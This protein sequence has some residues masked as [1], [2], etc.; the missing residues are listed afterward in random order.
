MFHLGDLAPT[1]PHF[2]YLHAH[3][4]LTTAGSWLKAC[5][6]FYSAITA[7]KIESWLWDGVNHS[8]LAHTLMLLE[9]VLRRIWIEFGGCQGADCCSDRQAVTQRDRRKDAGR[10]KQTEWLRGRASG[11]ASGQ[12]E[13]QYVYKCHYIIPPFCLSAHLTL[14]FLLAVSQSFYCKFLYYYSIAYVAFISL[15][16][17]ETLLLFQ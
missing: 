17:W 15:V 5:A 13:I 2:L 4:Y 11:T 14:M 6:P 8:N 16:M 3:L 7:S 12:I 1:Q 9:G 10:D